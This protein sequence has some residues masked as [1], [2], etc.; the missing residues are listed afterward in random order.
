MDCLSGWVNKTM[1]K[2]YFSSRILVLG[3]RNDEQG[4]KIWL[5]WGQKYK[6]VNF[7]ANDA[8]E[9]L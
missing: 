7:E 9:V 8:F 4:A 6:I 1:Q 5:N 3:L 2:L